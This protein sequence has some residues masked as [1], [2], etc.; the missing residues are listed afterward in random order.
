MIVF[1]GMLYIFQQQ[2]QLTGGLLVIQNFFISMRFT[3][4][5]G[6]D[7]WSTCFCSYLTHWLLLTKKNRRNFCCFRMLHAAT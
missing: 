1:F 2:K 4:L 6:Y 5:L 3:H 7:T